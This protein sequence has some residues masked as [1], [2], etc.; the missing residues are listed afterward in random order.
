MSEELQK[1]LEETKARLAAMEADNTKLNEVIKAN[2]TK[3]SGNVD[4]M[5]KLAELQKQNEAMQAEN[6]AMKINHVKME[7]VKEFPLAAGL[8]DEIVASDPAAIKDKAKSFHE[9]IAA[10]NE[11][12]VKAKEAEIAAAWGSIHSGSVPGVL[13]TEDLDADYQKARETKD[14][15]GMMKTKV[16]RLAQKMAS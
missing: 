14:Y 13:R 4:V 3:P 12:A 16:I 15:V 8:I 5:N 11:A 1:Q 2:A 10:A 9:K 7:A 6:M